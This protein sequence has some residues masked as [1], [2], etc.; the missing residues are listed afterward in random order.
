MNPSCVQTLMRGIVLMFF[1]GC[2]GLVPAHA[3][4]IQQL[5]VVPAQPVDNLPVLVVADLFFP[6]SGCPL[7]NLVINQTSPDRFEAS[8]LHCLGL[9]TTI[10]NTSDTFNLGIMP[11]GSYR[12]VLS[13]EYGWFP[14]PCTSAGQPPAID[15][16]DFQ[17]T[18]ASGTVDAGVPYAVL[19]PNPSADGLFTLTIKNLLTV[20]HCRIINAEGKLL[21]TFPAGSG[22]IRIDLSGYADG[23]YFLELWRNTERLRSMKMIKG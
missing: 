14:S 22:P 11:A 21:E 20:S 8:A 10:C 6:N 17:V 4:F 15:S 16:I 2:V 3:Q 12:F 5:R 18:V 1:L 19:R 9:L 13:E 7:G 23:F